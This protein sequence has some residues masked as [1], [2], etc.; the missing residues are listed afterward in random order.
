MANQGSDAETQQIKKQLIE[1]LPLACREMGANFFNC[2]EEN[3]EKISGEFTENMSY[4][5]VEKKISE[6][7]I[8]LCIQKYD[9]QKCVEDNAQK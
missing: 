1:E 9:V 2:V 6:R 7:V 3:M 8:P 4:E 5:E